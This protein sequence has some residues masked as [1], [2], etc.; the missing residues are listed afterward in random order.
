MGMAGF[1]GYGQ[2]MHAR[3][4]ELLA[5]KRSQPRT[6][7][8]A[9]GLL[10]GRNREGAD[11]PTYI[12]KDQFVKYLD[13]YIED[14][15]IR[16]R[17]RNRIE[18]CNGENSAEN[19]PMI[20]GLDSFPGETIHSSKYKS[21]AS[22]S[23]QKVLVVGCGNSGMEIAYDL[24]S[25]GANTSI[26]VR[27]PNSESMLNHDGLPKKQFPNHWKGANRLYCAGLAK[28]GLAG[29]A[30]D[31]KNIANDILRTIDLIFGQTKH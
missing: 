1:F 14:F 29:I 13:K 19:I 17:Y 20:P 5:I 21:G 6:A 3:Y 2:G 15:N 22:Y 31:A 25:H 7:S 4:N 16:P 8:N 24:A 27:S 18:S 11:A 30:M 9:S 28:R 10:S 26:V 23:G 12:P